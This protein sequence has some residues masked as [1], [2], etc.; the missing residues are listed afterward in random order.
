MTDSVCFSWVSQTGRVC[1]IQQTVLRKRQTAPCISV[2]VNYRESGKTRK[3]QDCAVS[4]IRKVEILKKCVC[5]GTSVPMTSGKTGRGPA[6]RDCP[7]GPVSYHRPRCHA[8]MTA[9]EDTPTMGKDSIERWRGGGESFPFRDES[10]ERL[11]LLLEAQKV[12]ADLAVAAAVVAL[13]DDSEPLTDDKATRVA[14]AAEA[15]QAV[16]GTLM[17]RVPPENRNDMLSD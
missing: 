14:E 2:S 13:L 1:E 9:R 6:A 12:E 17:L 15:L 5:S 10:D 16:A 11:A 3:P 7:I 8:T 4:E